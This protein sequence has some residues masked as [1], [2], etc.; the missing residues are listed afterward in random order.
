MK[1]FLLIFFGVV[2]SQQLSAQYYYDRSKNPDKTVI[3]KPSRDFDT[4]Y[5]FSW[6][7]NTPLSNQNFISQVSN[8][9]TRFG[10]RKRLNSVDRL[11]VGGE[12]GWSVYKDH[13]PFTTYQYGNTSIAAEVFNYSYN[14]SITANVDYFFFSMDKNIVPYA[15]VGIG[16]AYDKFAQYYNIYSNS[17]NSYGLQLRPEIGVL[18]GF[19]EN[20]SWRIK[21]AGHFD[22]ASNSGNLVNNNFITPGNDNY[23]G[24]LNMGLQ[25]G[26]VKMAW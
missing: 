19:K 14:Y 17:V 23:K 18:L 3:Q 12:V 6:D 4:Y 13:I 26:I 1:T 11:W 22:Y 16:L 15:G 10:M 21:V 2:C 20:S 25:I 7:N 9:G 8:L 5:F 24:F